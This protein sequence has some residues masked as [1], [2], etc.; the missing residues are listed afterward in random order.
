MKVLDGY[1]IEVVIPSVSRPMDTSCVV[2][3]TEAERF[4]NEILDYRGGLRSGNELL[5]ELQG[6]VKSCMKR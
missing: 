6:S 2:I 1:G 3:S 4:V 5:A